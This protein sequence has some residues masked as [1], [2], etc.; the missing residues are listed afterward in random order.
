VIAEKTAQKMLVV[1]FLLHSV[2]WGD[3]W[4]SRC[5]WYE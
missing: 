4:G 2:D 1:Y 3:P 5:R